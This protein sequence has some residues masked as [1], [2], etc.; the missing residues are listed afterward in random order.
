MYFSE[1]MDPPQKWSLD[2]YSSETYKIN[3]PH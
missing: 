1:N 3:G 2:R